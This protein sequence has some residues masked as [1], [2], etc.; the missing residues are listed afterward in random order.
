MNTQPDHGF[1][2]LGPWEKR[3]IEQAGST[4]P[5]SKANRARRRESTALNWFHK[6]AYDKRQQPRVQQQLRH[7]SRNA[8]F[9]VLQPLQ[10]R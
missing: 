8:L 6:T 4:P 1:Q 7:A 5:Q 9:G 3:G 10:R 2:G